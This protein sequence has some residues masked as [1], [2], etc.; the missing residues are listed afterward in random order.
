[1]LKNLLWSLL[2]AVLIVQAGCSFGHKAERETA[3]RRLTLMTWNVH[4]LFDG[5]DNGYEYNEFREFSGWSAEKYLGRINSISAAIA[6]VEPGPDIILLQEIESFKI[7]EDLALSMP[8]NYSWSHFANNP[9][10]AVG[11]GVISSILPKDSRVHSITINGETIPRPVMEIRFDMDGEAF[12]IFAC[13][14]K[15][16]ASGDDTTENIRRASARVILRRI[17]ELWG[18][19]PELGIIVAGDLNE[20]HDEFYK[21]NSGVICAL[22]GDDP[23]CVQLTGFL[24]YNEET[25]I[26][27]KDFIVISGNKPPLPV[28]F[29]Q[30]SI[31][32]FSPWMDGLENGS[33]YYK[34]NWE[35]IDHFLVSGQFF[36]NDGWEYEMAA[37]ADNKPFT[38]NGG[39]P[40]AYNARTGAG[41]SDHLPLI[42]SL[43][44]ISD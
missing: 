31:V 15:S 27:Q 12:V 36:N 14:W 5:S 33:Y 34:G 4:N 37:V 21:L 29:P 6:A 42:L 25:A 20:N 1:V 43:R 8:G 40:A 9:G 2:A 44:R 3:E 13:H 28:H 39:T 22:L 11:L 24:E 19:E 18:S 10:A 41:L 30:K 32:L 23:S 16:K 38:N 17:R 35:T 26:P 7:L